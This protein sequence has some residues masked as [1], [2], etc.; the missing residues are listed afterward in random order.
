METPLDHILSAQICVE[1]LKFDFFCIGSTNVHA[2]LVQKIANSRR[3]KIEVGTLMPKF[4]PNLHLIQTMTLFLNSN[5]YEVTLLRMTL[6]LVLWHK[7]TTIKDKIHTIFERSFWPK[8]NAFFVLFQAKPQEAETYLCTVIR[9]DENTTHYITG[10]YPL[11]KYNLIPAQMPWLNWTFEKCFLESYNFFYTFSS[12]PNILSST[13]LRPRTNFFIDW[14]M[15]AEWFDFDINWKVII[16][17][18]QVWPA[19]RDGDGP[20]YASFWLQGTWPERDTLQVVIGNHW[21]CCFGR[22]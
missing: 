22:S 5:I 18:E 9:L 7:Q 17:I 11:W 6:C 15:I 19:S 21:Q 12:I 3:R 13:V 1:N 8:C 2:T 16:K 10:W 14:I 4:S 20:S